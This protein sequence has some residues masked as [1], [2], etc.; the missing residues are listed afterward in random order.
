MD[1]E[2][3]QCYSVAVSTIS[4]PQVRDGL[5]NQLIDS[6]REML[7]RGALH[8]GTRLPPEREL[9]KQF[10]VSRVSLRHALKALELLGVIT[11]RVGDGTYLS[12][13]PSR[14]LDSAL[15]FLL[16]TDEINF[17]D[18]ID[19]RLMVE[20]ELASAAARHA[21]S[22]SVKELDSVL[23]AMHSEENEAKQTE[24][25]LLFHDAIFRASGNRLARRIFS[26]LHRSM[27][28]S[29][30][31]TSKLVSWEHTISF[32]EPIY[33]AIRDRK[34]DEARN[35]MRVHLLDARQLLMSTGMKRPEVD[36][37]RFPNLT[38][39]TVS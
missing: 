26:V 33:N 20:P 14:I 1:A 7:S 22:D 23:Q 4:T 37:T 21:T 35:S 39:R 2:T 25:D 6:F 12:P 34:E 32:H 15:D 16:L 18:V 19:T 13:D 27:T 24:L 8:W 5:T 11:Q 10:G 30:A 31:V 9:A 38:G 17:L 28:D 29:I 3:L 36:A